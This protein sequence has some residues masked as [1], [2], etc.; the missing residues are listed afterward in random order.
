MCNDWS[1]QDVFSDLYHFLYWEIFSTTDFNCQL[2]L[3]HCAVKDHKWLLSICTPVSIN[4]PLSTFLLADSSRKL[5]IFKTQNKGDWPCW[6]TPKAL[7]CYLGMMRL[8]FW[9][10]RWCCWSWLQREYWSCWFSLICVSFQATTKKLLLGVTDSTLSVLK[11]RS[12]FYLAWELLIPTLG[13]WPNP[14]GLQS[15]TVLQNKT[16]PERRQQTLLGVHD[17]YS[18]STRIWVWI[19]GA[20]QK[21]G[22]LKHICNPT[23]PKAK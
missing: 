22:S 23:V 9:E 6:V 21:P 3:L 4:Y 20:K 13:G 1:E 18:I 12:L 11:S 14:C 10:I 17:V 7:Q 2:P 19:S 5:C 16:G 8:H 15:G